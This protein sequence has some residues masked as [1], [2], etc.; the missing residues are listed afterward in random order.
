MLQRS[1]E[2]GY[3]SIF[4]VHR[5]ELINQTVRTL[6]EFGVDP[7]ILSA[8]VSGGTDD[9]IMVG[10][11]QTVTR[12]LDRI[13]DR[14][15]V[16]YD[17]CHHIAS[18]SWGRVFHSL[19]NAYHVGLS[20]TPERL[21]GRGLGEFFKKMVV[22][23]Q[24]K[25]LIDAGW[26][27]RY[28][29]FAPSTVDLKGVHSR[30]G[31]WIRGELSQ[32]VDR[33]GITGNAV[34]HYSKLCAG[35]RAIVFAVSIEHSKHIMQ[36]FQT[37][38]VN[39]QH[40]DG[41]TPDAER[42]EAIK[43]FSS[44]DIQVIC[45][46]DLFGEGFDCPGIE[47]A[48]LL[49]PTQSRSLYRQQIGRALRP[50]EGKREA[51]ILDHVGNCSRHGLP[52]DEYQWSLDGNP[53]RGKRSASDSAVRVCM[54]CFAANPSGSPTCGCCGAEFPVESRNIPQ[55]DGELTEID[56]EQQRAIKRREQ[57]QCNTLEQLVQLGTDRGYKNPYWW[58]RRVMEGRYAK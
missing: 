22:G 35:K 40:I 41:G 33:P 38:G 3:K 36:Q 30:A 1:A 8:S 26:L 52:D 50:V 32:A 43:R 5:R 4:L 31:D 51:I 6:R 57:G 56:I 49:R 24:V 23:P 12:H 13:Q 15:F 19:P 17:E 28:R 11:I 39:A 18:E 44:G 29:L 21:D 9:R 46:C 2:R 16:I 48:I 54:S 53:N 45:N 58:A 37:V 42:D 55:R 7:K 34:A 14:N 20:A 25:E 10:S 47:C 27:S